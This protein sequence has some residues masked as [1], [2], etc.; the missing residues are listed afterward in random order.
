MKKAPILIGLT[1]LAYYFYYQYI[2]AKK[3]DLKVAKIKIDSNWTKYGINKLPVV[4]TLNI[5]NPSDLEA[6][7]DTIKADVFLNDT[8]LAT[9]FKT[10]KIKIESKKNSPVDTTILIDISSA[11]ANIETIIEYFTGKQPASIFIKGFVN[12]SL[13]SYNFSKKINLKDATSL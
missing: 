5:Y 2:K 9:I 10:D 6:T 13:G 11:P 4:V 7:I 3:I 12:S 1:A 8:Y